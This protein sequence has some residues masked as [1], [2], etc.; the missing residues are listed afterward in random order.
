MN[1][2]DVQ[3][4]CVACAGEELP[5]SMK[6]HLAGCADCR[7]AYEAALT[8]AR[9]MSLKKYEVPDPGFEARSLARIR[10]SLYQLEEERAQGWKF[11]KLFDPS[12]VSS[13]RY[14]MAAMVL[15][16][17]G[18]YMVSLTTLPTAQPALTEESPSEALA[19]QAVA[20]VDAPTNAAIDSSNAVAPVLLAFS[21]ARPGRVEYGPG[22]SVPVSFRP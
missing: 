2:R 17:G 11:W 7:E 12:T 18:L 19:P 15:L 4:Y 9:L 13:A 14:A 8:V 10:T 1:C 20:A 21:N 6:Q 3:E 16:M 22:P 5:E